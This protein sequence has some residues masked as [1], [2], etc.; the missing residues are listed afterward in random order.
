MPQTLLTIVVCANR[1][2]PFFAAALQSLTEAQLGISRVETVLVAN[3]GWH[4]PVEHAALFDL[5]ITTPNSGLGRARNLGVENSSGDWISFFDSDDLMAP[6]YLK[7]TLAAIAHAKPFDIFF[8][9][10]RMI[11]TNGR[12]LPDR[13]RLE[14]LPNM[15]SLALAH[16]FTGATLVIRRTVFLAEGGYQWRGYAEDYDLSLRLFFSPQRLRFKR[17]PA[18]AYLYRQHDDTMSADNS[19]KIIG[20]RAVQLHHARSGRPILYVGALAS[21]L[22]LLLKRA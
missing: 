12:T 18:A 6:D 9:R 14:R 13:F 10:V 17:N 1:D 21:S 3:G 20:V 7:E 2:N 8:N 16:P 15:V 11:D 22:R 19:Q 4:P 5:V